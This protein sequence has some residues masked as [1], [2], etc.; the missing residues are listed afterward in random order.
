MYRA[1]DLKSGLF[2][3]WGWRQ[4]YNV[5]EFTLASSLTESETG[6][7]YQEVHP[8]LTLENI[9][10]IAPEFEALTLPPWLIG[11]QYRANDRVVLSTVLY[12]AKRDNLGQDPRT[13]TLDWEPYDAFSQWLEEKTKASIMTAIRSFWDA[14]MAEQTARNILESK[15]LFDGAGRLT[16]I[17]QNTGSLVGIEIVPVRSLGVTTKI[18]RIGLQFKGVGAITMYLLH[19]SQTVPVKTFTFTRTKDGGM[20]WFTPTDDLYLPYISESQDA[21]GSWYLVYDQN[22]LPAGNQAVKAN[23]D[24]SKDPCGSC[25]SRERANW[26]VWSRYL[27][28]YP[29]KVSAPESPLTMWDVADNLYTYETNWG[30][31]LQVSIE[32][33]ITDI[34]LN[35]KRAFQNIIGFQVAIDM[36]REMAYNPSFNVGRPQQNLSMQAILY[37]LDGDSQGYKKSGLVFQ[38]ANA[39]KAVKLDTHGM[40]RVCFPCNNRGLKFRTT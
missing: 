25:N 26:S 22:A 10:A 9:K 27:E 7:Y 17:M 12:R 19:S 2:G 29:F 33:D 39:M 38:Y 32:C 6:Q 5:S 1:N 24:W 23:K 30:L 36:L 20:E 8:L 3:L 34:V 16:D 18:D 37:E 4:N 31:N 40:S 14:K 21:G 28:V 11:T 15:A 35:Q 13:H